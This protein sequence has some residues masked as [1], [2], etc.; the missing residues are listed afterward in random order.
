MSYS[1]KLDQRLSPV[2]AE[3]GSER[4]KMFGGICYLINGNMMAGI[5]K[6][7]LILRLGP[8]QAEQ[9]LSQTHVRPFDITGRPMKGWVM[10]AEKGMRGQRLAS[11]LG[12][13]RTFA[14]GLPPK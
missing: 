3:W 5:Y 4:K 1:E 13:A 8:E 11:W 9:A 10:V 14:E 7:Y 2:M 12:K 6:D